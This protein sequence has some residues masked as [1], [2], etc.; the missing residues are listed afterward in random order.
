MLYYC[1]FYIPQDQFCHK[2]FHVNILIV[3]RQIHKTKISEIETVILKSCRANLTSI[4]LYERIYF[5]EW[6]H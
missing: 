4:P 5:C 6:Q 1:H 3:A 2:A